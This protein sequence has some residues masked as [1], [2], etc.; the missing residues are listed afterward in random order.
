MRAERDALAA[1]RSPHVVALAASFQD[2]THLHFVMEYLPGGDLMTLLMRAGT[3]PTARRGGGQRRGAVGLWVGRPRPSP[4]ASFALGSSPFPPTAGPPPPTPH[5][6]PFS[7]PA[8]QKEW[9]RFYTAQLVLALQAI[10][11]RGFAHRDV[12][13]DNLLLDARGHLKA[14]GG[15]GVGKGWTGVRPRAGAHAVL[16]RRPR[17]STPPSPP[18]SCLTLGCALPWGT[19]WAAGTTVAR[20]LPARAPNPHPLVRPRS[21]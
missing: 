10:H 13:P 12:K 9:A 14:G 2:A 18:L 20:A 19:W 15:R 7:F 6:L 1:A 3:L 4:A 17:P 16:S 8:P 21:P 11:A 5:T